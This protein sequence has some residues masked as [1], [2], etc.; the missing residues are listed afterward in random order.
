[1]LWGLWAIAIAFAILYCRS[2]SP[3][4]KITP[5]NTTYVL[6]AQSIARGQGYREGGRPA[7]LFP[8]GTSA[9]LS[10][11]W[12]IKK[13]YRAMNAEVVFFV[14][15][16]MTISYFLFR[17]S[18][19]KAGSLLTVLLCLGSVEL[20][21]I[22]TFILS[23]MFFLFFSLAAFWW[24]WRDNTV[25]AAL[26]VLCAV[27]VRTAGVC[28]SAAFLLDALRKRP[29][30]WTKVA[31]HAVPLLFAVLWEIRNR[32]L[33]LAYSSGYMQAEPWV[34]SAG[35]IAL[36]ALLI[37]FLNNL[38]YGRALVELMTN[39]WSQ[40]MWVVL[41][42]LLLAAVLLVGVM[43]LSRGPSAWRGMTIVGIYFLLYWLA[44]G[45]AAS[46]PLIRYL[47]PLLPFL[48]ACLIA[49]I[50]DL[51]H[52]KYFQWTAP[53]AAVLLGYYLITGFLVDAIRIVEARHP[54]F[55]YEA[56][57]YVKHYDLQSLALWWRDHAPPGD[58]ACEHANI[59]G[60]LTGRKGVVYAPARPEAVESEMRKIHARFLLLSLDGDWDRKTAQIAEQSGVFHLAKQ[61]GRARLYEL[62]DQPAAQ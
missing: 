62:A 14:L 25:G 48:F 9:L 23:E 13:S 12:R 52:R 56:V 3:F 61:Q 47:L 5:D 60:I 32:S 58:L 51:T 18:L 45:L 1:L 44:I 36:R 7:P 28:L 15:G 2:I 49:G 6:A 17:G 4:W 27:M 40:V 38:A 30:R 57:K 37:R 46:P 29:L 41:P 31:A 24:Y 33:G 35:R 55:P 21:D 8:P 19:G 53:A 39:G 50:Q 42:G 11:A 54:P 26:S 16:S 22:S 10:V 34:P 43:R 20:F 59:I